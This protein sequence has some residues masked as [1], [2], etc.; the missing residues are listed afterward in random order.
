MAVRGWVR[1]SARWGV[2][3]RA[4]VAAV[5]VLTGALALAAVAL[6]WLLQHSLQS[7]ADAAASSRAEQL[8]A[9]LLTVP[10]TEIDPTLLATDGRTTVI[11]VSTSGS[12]TNTAAT[13]HPP[14]WR[15]PTTLKPSPAHR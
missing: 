7:A 14:N 15:P 3:V 8:S 1:V 2:R 12:S 10:V 6:L 13:S 11:Q 9:R 4:A 5:V